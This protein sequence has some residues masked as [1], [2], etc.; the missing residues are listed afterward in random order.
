MSLN[1]KLI[2]DILFFILLALIVIS[3]LQVFFGL[4]LV[5]IDSDQP[6]MWIGAK[7]YSEGNFYEPR[8]Y[9]QN[10][11]TFMEGFFAVPFIWMGLKVYQAVPLA[12]HI[13]FLFPFVFTAIYLYCKNKKANALITLAIMACMPAAYDIL[14]ALPRGFI[15][16][17]F[18]SSFFIMS[19]LNPEKRSY[20]TLNLIMTV[21][22][23]VVNPNSLLISVPVQAF[24]F[25]H[26][27]R[28]PWYYLS[29]AVALSWFVILSLIFDSFYNQHPEYIMY[30]LSY[31]FSLSYFLP[32]LRLLLSDSFLHINFFTD[33]HS[34]F[35]F[36]SVLIIMCLLWFKNKKALLAFSSIFPVLLCLCF[37]GKLTDGSTWPY[38]SYSRLFIGLPMVLYLFQA[39]LPA[40]NTNIPKLIALTGIVFCS[41]KLTAF[42]NKTDF[43]TQHEKWTHLRMVKLEYALET[44]HFYKGVCRNHDANNILI[45]SY[46]WLNTYI[47]CGGPATDKDYPE[48]QE[49]YFEKRYVVREKNA[50]T[51]TRTFLL[52]AYDADFDKHVSGKGFETER[53]DDYGMFLIKNNTLTTNQFISVL[54]N[55][56]V[57]QRRA[58]GL[59]W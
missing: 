40:D 51:I 34:L 44:I 1:K 49:T 39:L 26:N 10:Y 45:S 5:W 24:L 37:S 2:T 4:N 13:I 23:F 43:Y 7:D 6:Y 25:I 29:L 30:G 46:F 57:P 9:G 56:E 35:L 27:F 36:L 16:G 14:C 22:G 33:Q 19:L 50:N 8:Y 52:L 53:L 3:K 18:F 20:L 48:T 28:R 55:C 11:N 32:N 15:T 42:K 41:Y 47:S 54:E 17:V 59:L 38:Y 21:T 31:D 58:Q 12:T